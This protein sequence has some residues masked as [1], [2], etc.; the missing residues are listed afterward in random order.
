ML[1]TLLSI[2]VSF[3]S[4]SSNFALIFPFKSSNFLLMLSVMNYTL[5]NLN[6]YLNVLF[7]IC[8]LFFA[9]YVHV[10]HQY[11]RGLYFK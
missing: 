2:A 6:D 1:S 4:T 9:M 7:F 8:S 11:E 5:S 3:S 10:I